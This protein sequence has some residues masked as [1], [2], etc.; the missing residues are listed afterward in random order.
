VTDTLH[1]IFMCLGRAAQLLSR[2]S[3][4][5][6]RE[7]ETSDVQLVNMWVDFFEGIYGGRP[8]RLR[9]FPL[10][11]SPLLDVVHNIK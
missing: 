10:V 7:L 8:Q 1:E 2:P 6:I 3:P 4:V 11:S 9:L 5:S